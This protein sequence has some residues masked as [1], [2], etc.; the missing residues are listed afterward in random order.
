MGIFMA[1][2]EKKRIKQKTATPGAAT[3]KTTHFINRKCV[4]L[5]EKICTAI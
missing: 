3:A 1:K 4:M 5:Y 2:L